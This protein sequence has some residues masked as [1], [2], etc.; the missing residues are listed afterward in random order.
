VLPGVRAASQV[1]KPC[2]NFA[3]AVNATGIWGG[4]T[5]RE[6]QTM[7]GKRGGTA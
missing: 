1:R 6:R 4:T 3:L 5:E 7:R 2:L